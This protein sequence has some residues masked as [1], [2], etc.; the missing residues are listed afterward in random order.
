MFVDY[1]TLS[2]TDIRLGVYHNGYNPL[3]LIGKNAS[4]NGEEWQIKRQQTNPEEIKLWA[5]PGGFPHA[6]NTG[7]LTRRTP[8]LDLDI[9][10]PDAVKTLEAYV[11]EHYEELGYLLTRI[12]L[13]PKLAI[14]FRTEEPFQKITLPLIAINETDPHRRNDQKFEFLANGQQVAAFGIHPDTHKPYIW[15]GG[16]PLDV[17]WLELPYIRQADAERIINELGEIITDAA[18]KF[19]YEYKSK[20]KPTSCGYQRE[21]FA[22]APWGEYLANAIDDDNN[23]AFAMALLRSGMDDRAAE[24]L[25]TDAI[26]NLKDV[27]EARRQRRLNKKPHQQIKSA[28]RKLDAEAKPD[29]PDE[30]LESVRGDSIPMTAIHWLW[31]GRFAFRK[32]GIIAGL[33][34]EGKGQLIWFIIAMTTKP[35]GAFP[36]G[37]GDAPIGNVVVLEA[38]DDLSDTVIPR[39]TAAGADLSRVHFVNMVKINGEGDKRMFSLVNDLLML[40]K[41]IQEIGDVVLVVVDPITA[42]LGRSKEVDTFRTTDVR[43]AL[44]PFADLASELN[45]A[46]IAIMHFNKK[47]DITNVLLRLSDSAAFGAIARQ[48]YG[49]V[50]DPDNKRKLFVRGKNNNAPMEQK[51]LAYRF[52]TRM[53]G[54]ADSG[55]EIWAPHIIFEPEPV[56]V[57][58][59]EAM[60]GSIGR[61]RTARNGAEEFLKRK[62]AYGPVKKDDIEDE[63]EANGISRSTLWR[64]KLEMRIGTVSRRRWLRRI[65]APC[66]RSIM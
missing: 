22:R 44:A 11:R 19:G 48:V 50:D 41:K 7:L 65:S 57:T 23:T 31:P 21:P 25:L 59:S 32:I 17:P 18:A 42:Y 54:H 62:L 8:C 5:E 16:S 36:C 15:P 58:P 4:V 47:I 33:P 56:D 60:S 13:W 39:L 38:E 53:V 52:G 63:A 26:N 2:P 43:N 10:N 29:D 3:P 24:N 49:V 27:D 35:G 9:L 55:E 66:Q 46:I 51:T 28:R 1:L 61:P 12:G 14:I 6:T 37:E 20:T 40:R 30:T 64:A 34:G 45:V